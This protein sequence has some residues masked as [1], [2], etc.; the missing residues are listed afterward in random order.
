M[1]ISSVVAMM[2]FADLGMG[3]GLM[4]AI[5]EADGQ[6]DR[7]AAERYVSSGFFMLSAVA[8][9]ILVGFAAAFPGYSLATGI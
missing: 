5:S 6:D 1:T 7:L 9:I 2:G 3:S 4:N 8:L